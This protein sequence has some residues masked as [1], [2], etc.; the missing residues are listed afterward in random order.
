MPNV[1]QVE[2]AWLQA[3]RLPAADKESLL[4]LLQRAE[5]RLEG[6]I[7]RA[8]DSSVQ[9]VADVV[10]YRTFYARAFL[11]MGKPSRALKLLAAALAE[12]AEA[13]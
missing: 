3:T 10:R 9:Y 2:S 13:L 5:E 1:E 7:P 8:P 12:L 6:A 4:Q 11:Y